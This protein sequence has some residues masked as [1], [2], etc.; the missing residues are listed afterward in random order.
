MLLLGCCYIGVGATMKKAKL[1]YDGECP[2]CAHYAKFKEL[3]ACI[4]L[5][6][7]DAREDLSY[8]EHNRDIKLDDGVILILESGEFFQG[9]NAINYLHRLCSF[10]GFFFHIQKWVFSKPMLAS[11]VYGILKSLRWLALSLKRRG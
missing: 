1:Y 11:L 6:L 4:N 5:E 8:K 9:V 2:F 10:D 7:C 3:R